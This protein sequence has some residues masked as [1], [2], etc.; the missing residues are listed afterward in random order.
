MP[1]H[2]P[3]LS[4]LLQYSAGNAN[5]AVALCIATH[6]HHCEACQ[7]AVHNLN[8]Y[9]GELLE[10]TKPIA[11]GADS[12]SKVLDAIQGDDNTERSQPSTS[13]A[14]SAD[15]RKKVIPSALSAYASHLP[16]PLQATLQKNAKS[17][18][19]K[20]S[21][22]LDAMHIQVGQDEYEANFHRIAKG[23]RVLEHDHRGNEVTVVLY[24][25]FSDESGSYQV[26]DYVERFPGQLHTPTATLDSECLCLSIVKAPVKLTGI[27]NRFIN[28][29]IPHRPA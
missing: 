27:L 26:G 11:P 7:Q 23:G 22:C 10:S 29:F 4:D 25:S 16:K 28:P 14:L 5:S 20:L 21:S 2:H 18:W 12:F 13:G 17:E 15:S 6:L 24:G 3:T 8:R 1:Q 19:K 9:G